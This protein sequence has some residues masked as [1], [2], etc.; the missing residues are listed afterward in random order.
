MV[1]ESGCLVDCLEDAAVPKTADTGAFHCE[2]NALAV[3]L[4]VLEISIEGL[5]V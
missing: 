1:E 3:D 4:V 5:A 2:V